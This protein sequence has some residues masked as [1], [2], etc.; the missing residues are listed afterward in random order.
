MYIFAEILY[1]VHISILLHYKNTIVQML[2]KYTKNQLLLFTKTT[3]RKNVRTQ[4][5]RENERASKPTQANEG[6]NIDLLPRNSRRTKKQKQFYT[7][8]HL[9]AFES[10]LKSRC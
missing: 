7:A 3:L 5:M 9:R 10:S 1:D 2:S 8:T 4:K 6:K